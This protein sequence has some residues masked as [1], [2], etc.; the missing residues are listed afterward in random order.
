[1]FVV[2]HLQNGWLFKWCKSILGAF[3]VEKFTQVLSYVVCTK[4]RKHVHKQITKRRYGEDKPGRFVLRKPVLFA[5]SLELTTP[6]SMC[7]LAWNFTRHSSLCL[8]SFGWD[9]SPKFVPQDLQYI[10][11]SSLPGLEGRFVGVWNCLIFFPCEYS[12]VWPEICRVLSQ[13]QS[14]FLRGIS[15]KNYFGRI[16]KNFYENQGYPLPKLVKFVPTFSN[17]I[18][19]P[20]CDEKVHTSAFICFLPPDKEARP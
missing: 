17:F 6:Y 19:G 8:F 18:L 4:V 11:S 7:I 16:F 15:G 10:F 14:R 13:I 3:C 1:M 12:S 2:F 20:F 5:L 9:L